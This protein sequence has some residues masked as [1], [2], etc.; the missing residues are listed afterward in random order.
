M[1]SSENK[2]QRGRE[3]MKRYV[4]TMKAQTQPTPVTFNSLSSMVVSAKWLLEEK[5][6]HKIFPF[7][8]REEIL[9]NINDMIT[10][11]EAA[12]QPLANN[13]FIGLTLTKFNV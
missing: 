13:M 2:R 9:S 8:E 5:K 10:N 1:K 7:M 11:A 12:R 6:V 4:A 3:M